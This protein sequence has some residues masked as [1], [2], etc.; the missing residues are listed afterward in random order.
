MSKFNKK[1]KECIFLKN[2]SAFLG[3][4]LLTLCLPTLGTARYISD[5]SFR[6]FH[7]MHQE[8]VPL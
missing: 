3:G 1:N 4:D 2:L 7:L 6:C 8:Q 5:I